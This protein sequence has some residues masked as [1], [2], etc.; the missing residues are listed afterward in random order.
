M[1]GLLRKSVLE[2]K[3]TS[4]RRA[5]R[6]NAFNEQMWDKLILQPQCFGQTLPVVEKA[7]DI[8]KEGEKTIHTQMKNIKIADRSEHGWAIVA[9]YK[10]DELADNSDDEK[11]LFWSGVRAGRKLK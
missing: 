6:N 3:P 5:T 8:L 9:E 11:R 2:T 7:K 1:S 4:V 10:E